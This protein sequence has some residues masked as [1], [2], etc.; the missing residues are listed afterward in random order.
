M[1]DEKR[2]IPVWIDAALAKALHPDLAKRYEEHSEFMHDLRHP[3]AALLGRRRSPL[4]ER[5][6]V[7]F[8]KCLSFALGV[9][10]IVLL[11]L[12]TFK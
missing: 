6:P 5:N 8:W 7:F 4:I 9:A 1:L 12:R 3:N 10:V 11:G 2:E